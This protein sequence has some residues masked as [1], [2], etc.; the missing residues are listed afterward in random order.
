MRI[1]VGLPSLASGVPQRQSIDAMLAAL[2]EQGHDV[3]GF[4][5]HDRIGDDPGFPTFH[6]LRL[7][8]RHGE[9]PF[10][11]AL[12]PLGRDATPYQSVLVSMG[13]LPGMVWF[14]DPVVHHLVVGGV[15]LLDDW[16]AYRRLLDDAY[17]AAGG[18]IA[19]TVASNWGTG[20]LFRRYDLAAAL[21]SGQ[22]HVVAAWPALATRVSSRLEDRPVPVVPL[23]HVE[24]EPTARVPQRVRRVAI[25]TVNDS[26]ATSA[27]RAAAAAVAVEGVR[28]K[29][30]LSEP[31]YKA[32]GRRVARHLE[33]DECIDWELTTAP[34]RLAAVAAESDV[35]AWLAEEL[36]GGH[37][38][39]MLDC[40]AAGKATVVPRCALYD[41]VPDGAVAR[42]D[43]GCSV[44]PTFGA[45]LQA[46]VDDNDLCRGLVENGRTFAMGRASV[47]SATRQLE[48]QLE[49][50]ATT[51]LRR[52]SVSAPTWSKTREQIAGFS[53]PGGASAEVAE[54]IEKVIRS[55]TDRFGR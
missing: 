55:S 37:R 47:E 10:D 13:Q 11:T 49:I 51:K 5:E 22:R 36:Q 50:A 14:L 45:I 41:D 26:Y 52:T 43:L 33:I 53:V 20:A 24:R 1:A 54:S 35:V 40:M 46:L 15:A 42:L 29:I 7:G 2:S 17:G 38:L 48:V 9:R 28:V 25:M 18:A 19:Q 34:E 30:C 31:I 23:G 6:Y 4:A 21:T 3:E 12:Y 44:G 32:E 27:V 8:E 39:L 16:A